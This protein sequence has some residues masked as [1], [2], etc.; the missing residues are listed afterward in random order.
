MARPL[1]TFRITAKF[2]AGST[3]EQI[4][5]VTKQAV[6]IPPAVRYALEDF[7]KRPGVWKHRHRRVEILVEEVLF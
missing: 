3:G 1:R 6:T 4:Q 7:L 5:R 2:P